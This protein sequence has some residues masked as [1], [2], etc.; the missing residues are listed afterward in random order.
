MKRTTKLAGGTGIAG[1]GYAAYDNWY[2]WAPGDVCIYPYVQDSII[3]LLAIVGS[4]AIVFGAI[5]LWRLSRRVK[6]L[7]SRS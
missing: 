7:E 5:A 1:S 3:P 6:A 2:C 4:F